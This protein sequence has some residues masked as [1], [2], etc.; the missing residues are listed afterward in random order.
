ML[1]SN[2]VEPVLSVSKPSFD[3]PFQL[4]QAEESHRL[5]WCKIKCEFLFMEDKKTIYFV[6][7][8]H[9]TYVCNDIF[10]LLFN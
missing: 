6:S 4:K 2:T 5:F 8:I 9:N 7:Y 10:T 3:Y 1:K